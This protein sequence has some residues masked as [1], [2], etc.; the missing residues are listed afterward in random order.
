MALKSQKY[1]KW[2]SSMLLHASGNLGKPYNNTRREGDSDHSK[3]ILAETAKLTGDV[4]YG[5]TITDKEK[6]CDTKYTCS[7]YEA[8]NHV[9]NTSLGE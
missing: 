8:T 7:K 6:I 4:V 1:I 3:K 2:Y 9:N 5:T